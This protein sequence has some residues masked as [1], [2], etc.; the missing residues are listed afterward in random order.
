MRLRVV[1]LTAIAVLSS[2]AIAAAHPEP[3]DVDGDNVRDEND[4]C[5]TVYN[6][7][8][9]DVDGDRTGNRCDP[10]W[11][12]DGDGVANGWP[13]AVDNCKTVPNPSQTDA[14]GDGFGDE[15]DIDTDRDGTVDPL[16]NCPTVPNRFQGNIDRDD[17]GDDCDP[18]I[19]NDDVD[20]PAD[21]SNARDNCPTVWNP[22]QADVD[23]DGLGSLCDA[24]EPLPPPPPPGGGPS[25]TAGDD[26]TAPTVRASMVSGTRVREA[27]SGLIVQLRCSEACVASAELRIDRRTAQR[28][29]L[30]STRRL[31]RG[32]AQLD[33]AGTT[34][35]FLKLAR[36][37]RKALGR[38]P[39]TRAELRVVTTDR[40]AN[41]RTSTRRV[42]LRR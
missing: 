2:A 32:T 11:D 12:Q 30:G 1:L 17:L 18:D 36:R 28:L 6:P 9:G 14:D 31:G 3:G 41:R 15:C 24:V 27:G 26:R 10:D 38:R 21:L 42:T 34:Y 13:T 4:N 5:V 20:S 39:S 8:Q 33:A 37:V 29:R 23:R 16:D 35:A 25:G 7:D 40:A 19:D 22:D